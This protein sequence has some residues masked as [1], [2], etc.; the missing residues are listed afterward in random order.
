MFKTTRAINALNQYLRDN[1]YCTGDA[2]YYDCIEGAYCIDTT[3]ATEYGFN[4]YTDL[5][6]ADKAALTIL[7]SLV[8]YAVKT[9]DA[10]MVTDLVIVLTDALRGEWYEND[11]YRDLI[12]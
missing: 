3:L 8:D 11:D 12:D 4:E 1:K 10:D 5:S 6:S 7:N 9:G 2:I